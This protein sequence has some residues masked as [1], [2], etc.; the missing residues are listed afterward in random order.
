M[1][2]TEQ[3]EVMEQAHPAL[4]DFLETWGRHCGAPRT[5]F[6]GH[7]CKLLQELTARRA[8]PDATDAKDAARY[9]WIWQNGMPCQQGDECGA[10]AGPELDAVID[11]AIERTG[12]HLGEGKT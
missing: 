1:N 5:V 12:P 11:A 9:A 7:L 8:E 10:C 2:W 3:C 4:H 6:R